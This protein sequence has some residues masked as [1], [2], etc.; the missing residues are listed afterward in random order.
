[1]EVLALKQG[2]EIGAGSGPR[3]EEAAEETEFRGQ[4][5]SNH[6]LRGAQSRPVLT[7]A[8]GKGTK[9]PSDFSSVC[10]LTSISSNGNK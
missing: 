7:T 9:A 4:S 2:D 3:P 1:M 8:P 5:C 10:G 6:S